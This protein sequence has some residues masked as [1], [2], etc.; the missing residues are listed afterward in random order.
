MAKRKRSKKYLIL[1]K[2]EDTKRV[3]RSHRS[4]KDMKYIGYKKRTKKH[5]V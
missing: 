3:A 5:I 4:Q 2:F 1:G